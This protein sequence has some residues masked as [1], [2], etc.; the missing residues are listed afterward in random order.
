MKEEC[1]EDLTLIGHNKEKRGREKQRLTSPIR[2]WKDKELRGMLLKETLLRY[3]K[4][5]KL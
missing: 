2:L 1:L 5:W 4:G 3:S